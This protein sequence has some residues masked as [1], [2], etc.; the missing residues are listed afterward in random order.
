MAEK[1]VEEI[2]RRTRDFGIHNIKIEAR[3][4]GAGRDPALKRILG[5]KSLNVEEII[6][7]TPLPHGGCR[8]RKAP[9]K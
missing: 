4:I 8:P 2:I 6:D 5:E 9:R 7:K 1:T 3:G